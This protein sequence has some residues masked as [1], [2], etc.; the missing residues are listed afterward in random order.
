MAVETA[1]PFKTQGHFYQKCD[2]SPG[3]S[4]S[5]VMAEPRQLTGSQINHY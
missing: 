3:S 1:V 4:A 5:F 2:K